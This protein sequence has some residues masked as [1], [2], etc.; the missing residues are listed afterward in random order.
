MFPTSRLHN[1]VVFVALDG[2]S[3]VGFDSG[4]S[5]CHHQKAILMPPL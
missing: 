4:A 1:L 2:V 3:D 5:F